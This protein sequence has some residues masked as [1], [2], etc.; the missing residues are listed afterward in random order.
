[1]NKKALNYRLATKEEI[2][3][4]VRK[5]KAQSREAIIWL[6]SLATKIRKAAE[7]K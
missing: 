4:K 7:G 6:R 2:N 3:A 1:M 5:M